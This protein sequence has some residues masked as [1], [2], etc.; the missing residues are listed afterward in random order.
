MEFNEFRLKK[1]PSCP[2]CGDAP[3][4]TELIDY[5][6]FCGMPAVEG[7]EI[8][9]PEVDACRVASRRKAGES[10]LLLDVRESAEV[11]Q[12]RISGAKW[13]PL[14]SLPRRMEEL[15]E[16]RDGAV[17]VHCHHGSRSAQACE[18]LLERGFRQVEN[19]TGGIEAWSL[20]VDGSVPRY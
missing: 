19:M 20:T 16:W 14:T 12:A 3:S 2:V 4:V 7:P 13:I 8:T 15:S 6:G 9:V 5:E 1:D 17:V 11:E 18:M 10:L